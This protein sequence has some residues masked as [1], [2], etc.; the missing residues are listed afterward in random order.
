MEEGN[1]VNQKEGGVMFS[2]EGWNERGVSWSFVMGEET[3]YYG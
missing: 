3:K 2:V 1:S